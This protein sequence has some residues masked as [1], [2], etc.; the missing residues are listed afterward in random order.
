MMDN[1][2]RTLNLPI[3]IRIIA[4]RLLQRVMDLIFKM[5]HEQLFIT[6]TVDELLFRGY[7]INVLDHIN[8]ISAPLKLFNIHLPTGGLIDG[9]F[10]IFYGKN[11]SLSK[12][13][14]IF[15]DAEKLG[16]I[17]SYGGFR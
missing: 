7:K 3:G 9:T 4:E 14:E 15:S 8:T 5:Y 2:T 10:G 12:K 16:Q 1:F 13:I 6:I 17:A 11:S